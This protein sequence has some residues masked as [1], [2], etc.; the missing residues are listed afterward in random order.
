MAPRRSI[1]RTRNISGACKTVGIHE[2]H[3]GSRQYLHWAV[4]GRHLWGREKI[5]NRFQ[6]LLTVCKYWYGK[7]RYVCG[8]RAV[9]QSITP[10]WRRIPLNYPT[11]MDHRPALSVTIQ[12]I[13]S[14]AQHNCSNIL[15]GVHCSMLFSP[16]APSVVRST[17]A[18]PV[19]LLLFSIEALLRYP[20]TVISPLV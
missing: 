13:G 17:A 1:V 19:F 18:Q 20:S 2:R 14:G 6:C 9:M 12:H 8:Q 4:S 15:H 11:V 3:N 7:V 16:Q 10:L 5:S